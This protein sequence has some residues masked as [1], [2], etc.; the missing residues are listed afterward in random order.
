MTAL[1]NR[2]FFTLAVTAALMM[3]G[4]ALAQSSQDMSLLTEPE[5]VEFT[6]RLQHTSSSAERAKITAE[7]N[8]VVQERRLELRRAKDAEVPANTP[9]KNGQ[10]AH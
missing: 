4:Q 10:P 9:Q 7:M 1:P 5:R 2:L 3:G 8:R 6:R